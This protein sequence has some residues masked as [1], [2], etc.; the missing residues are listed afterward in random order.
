[1]DARTATPCVWRLTS[2]L[3]GSDALSLLA[4]PR[5][6]DPV[7]LVPNGA[8]RDVVLT[9]ICLTGR[10]IRLDIDDATLPP[11][12]GDRHIA[13]AGGDLLAGS[14]HRRNLG[15]SCV[16][17]KDRGIPD[18]HGFD[19]VPRIGRHHHRQLQAGLAGVVGEGGRPCVDRPGLHRAL[20]KKAEETRL[21]GHAGFQLQDVG[22]NRHEISPGVLVPDRYLPDFRLQAIQYRPSILRRA[23]ATRIG[24]RGRICETPE[25][26]YELQYL[27]TP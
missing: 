3:E 26:S 2:G 17:A 21:S 22:A 12:M 11:A 19:L 6:T 23:M 7:G 18:D 24:A 16:H 15:G 1:I 13:E 9:G 8:G 10:C 27:H 4:D 25:V 20:K 5:L 14:L